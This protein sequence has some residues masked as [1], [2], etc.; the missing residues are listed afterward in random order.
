MQRLTGID[1]MFIYSDTSETPMEI[2]YAC[3]LDPATTRG[4]YSV[5]RVRDLLLTRLPSVPPLRRRLMAVPLGLDHPRWVDDSEFDL[6]N[7]LHRDALP[8]PGGERE[9]ER[10]V[11]EVLE[12][13]LPPDQPPWEIHLV[14][15]LDGGMI[16]L[17]AKVH[18]CVIDGIAGTETL[19]RFLDLSPDGSGESEPAVPWDPS[20]LPS[21]TRLV[22][23]AL[24][25]VLRSPV[26]TMRAFR[27]V[28]RT[29]GRLAR[30]A[31]DKGTGPLSVPGGAPS[32][33]ET[34]VSSRRTVAFA[35][36]DMAEVRALK[37]RFG[38]TVNDIALAVCSGALRNHLAARHEEPDTPLV[39]VVPV[40]V[41]ADA[42][43]TTTG[44]Q[45]SAMFVPLAN[46]RQSPLE[47]LRTV[48]V[49][50]AASKSQ[51]RAAGFGPMASLVADAIPPVVAK[52][53]VQFG[54]RA[55]LVRH[56]RAANL[57]ISN[58]PGPDFPLYFAGM[59]LRT[60]YPLGPVID[61]LALNITVQS[62]LDSLFFGINAAATA[63][64]DPAGLAR[65]MGDEL[66]LLT[67][68]ARG[69]SGRSARHGPPRARSRAVG[70]G[71][72][73]ALNPV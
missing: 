3:V 18:H 17:I 66:A 32:T 55:G 1:P 62:Y 50:S 28:G 64:P 58:V 34:R 61:G 40:S 42:D 63:V 7:H 43:G 12:N 73:S 31:V 67:K 13:P 10:M 53:V 70:P 23:D 72:S 51:E 20:P 16:G 65:A 27:E 9:L 36:L 56:L 35:E 21:Q 59:R 54:V 29:A 41:R 5:T 8:A 57:M 25:D 38:S 15:G 68:L 46:D 49:T 19:A 37:E 69:V 33:F 26:R 4:G 47:R 2:A 24:P 6:D 71:Q 60:L 52:P 39:A 30:R 11:A 45:L 44:N 14:E 48:T 22:S